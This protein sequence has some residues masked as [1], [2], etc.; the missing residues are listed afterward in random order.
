TT[1]QADESSVV[2]DFSQGEPSRDDWLTSG[3]AYGSQP[4][5]QGAVLLTVKQDGPRLAIADRAAASNLATS[6]AL[7]GIYRT[8]TVTVAGKTMWYRYRG[9][10]RVFLDVDSH[11][12][13]ASPLHEICKQTIESPD[14]WEWFAH[15]VSDY[16]GHR[17]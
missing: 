13:V 16:Q 6:S 9:S 12:T 14:K 2:V 11:R 3:V 15:D 7:S 1:P 17:V 4:L 8:R 10:A 5:A